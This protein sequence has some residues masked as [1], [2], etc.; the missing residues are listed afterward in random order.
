MLVLRY[1]TLV[2]LE[3]VVDERLELSSLITED[4]RVV[5]VVVVSDDS[6]ESESDVV[7]EELPLPSLSHEIIVRLKRN[8]TRYSKIVFIISLP[9]HL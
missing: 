4:A 3:L 7:E 5:V 9:E 8:T 6:D 2:C 1:E